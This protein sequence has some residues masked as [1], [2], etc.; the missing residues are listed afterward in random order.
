MLFCETNFIT[1]AAAFLACTVIKSNYEKH[2][3]KGNVHKHYAGGHFEE[4]SFK[5]AVKMILVAV[6]KS[7]G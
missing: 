2:Y 7:F 3:I 5:A 6:E 1:K 4:V